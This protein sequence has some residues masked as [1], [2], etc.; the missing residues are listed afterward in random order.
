[1][2]ENKEGGFYFTK[3]MRGLMSSL[4]QVQDFLSFVLTEE[5]RSPDYFFRQFADFFS[6]AKDFSAHANAVFD[7]AAEDLSALK[8][9]IGKE[10]V[11]LKR[12]RQKGPEGEYYSYADRIAAREELKEEADRIA[13]VVEEM[14]EGV[15]LFG[16]FF[17]VIRLFGVCADL[18]KCRNA[19]DVSRWLYRHTVKTYKKRFSLTGV[20]PSD[21]YALCCALSKAGR[22]LTPRY[23]LVF[24]DEGQDISHTEYELL[25]AIHSD[26]AFNVFG[27]LKQNITPWRGLTQW[28]PFDNYF[29]LD[30]NYRNTNEIVSFVAGNLSVKMQ[31]IGMTGSEVER[32]PLKRVAAWFRGKQGLKA[33]IVREEDLPL[34]EKRGFG[35]LSPQGASKTRINVMTVFESKGLEFS[36]VAVLDKGMTEHEKYIAYTRA[37]RDLAVIDC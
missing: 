13:G 9:T 20:Y 31:P 27:D 5:E 14:Q 2:K 21:A 19:L 24:I 4:V 17:A 3:P 30:V 6:C 25:R 36:A 15:D 1:M 37:L 32:I 35:R 18:G 23:G 26:A 7:R 34:F 12:Y 10:I 8:E 28:E 11:D 22:G 16:E 29:E 33:V